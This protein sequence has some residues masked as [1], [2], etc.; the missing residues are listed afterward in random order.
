M[1]ILTARPY[2]WARAAGPSSTVSTMDDVPDSAAKDLFGEMEK[3]SS[4]WC[5]GGDGR[6]PRLMLLLSVNGAPGARTMTLLPPI[7]GPLV[8]IWD[9]SGHTERLGDIALSHTDRVMA[10]PVSSSYSTCSRC[11][12]PLPDEDGAV[13]CPNCSALIGTAGLTDTAKQLLSLAMFFTDDK[14]LIGAMSAMA[15]EVHSI[16]QKLTA[17]YDVGVD[18]GPP[19]GWLPAGSHPH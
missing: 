17:E 1:T 8:A 18:P 10:V 7:E 12:C 15:G 6:L 13:R 9:D 14:A 2:E 11:K 19:H 4:E 3:A 5:T 16:R